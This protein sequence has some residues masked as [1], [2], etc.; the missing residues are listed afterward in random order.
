MKKIL[1]RFLCSLV[2]LVVSSVLE[3]RLLHGQVN[4]NATISS[5]VF[6]QP[7][8]ISTKTE[9][10]GAV[11][12]LLWNGKQFVDIGPQQ[13]DRGREFQ[14]AASF[15]KKYECYNPT[16][17]GANFDSGPTSS[18]QLLWLNASGNTLESQTLMAFFRAEEGAEA[19]CGDRT[20]WEPAPPHNYQPSNYQ[21]HKKITIGYAG[22]QNVIEWI[23]DLW[24]PEHITS[25]QVETMVAIMPYEF[26]PLWSYDLVSKTFRNV[27]STGGED[28]SVKVRMADNNHALAYYSPERLQPY[29]GSNFRW[30]H[31]AD[32]GGFATMGGLH[33]F[34]SFNG[35]GYLGYR[36]YLVI[37]NKDQVKAGLDSLHQQFRNLDPDVFNWRQYLAMY[38]DVAAS[39]PDQTGAEGHWLTYG[40]NEGRIGSRTFS[41][42]SY[43]QLNPDVANAFG[44]TNYSGAIYHYMT[45]GRDEGRGTVPKPAC[46]A[47]HSLGYTNRKVK[48]SGS[49]GNGQ[50]GNGT[51]TSSSSPILI[52][53]LENL[54]TEVASREY[55]SLAVKTDGTL[56]M[57]GSNQNGALGNG[58]VGGNFANAV[59]VVIPTVPGNPPTRVATPLRGGKHGIATGSGACA[60][61]DRDGQVWTWGLNYNGCLG[62]GTTTPHYIPARVKKNFTEYLTGI[63]SISVD[64]SRMAAVDADAHVWTW[65]SG[66][67]GALGN[68]STLDSSY[69]VQVK[70]CTNDVTNPCVQEPLPGVT[71]TACGYGFCI[72][73]T[74]SGYVYGWGNNNYAQLGLTGGGYQTLATRVPISSGGAVKMIAAGG[75]HGLAVSEDG[76]V[77]GWGFNGTGALGNGS[78][79]TAQAP[80]V[81]MS[82]GPQ[83]MNNI[84]DVVAGPFCSLMIRNSD[85]AVFG[86][87][88]NFAGQLGIPGGMSTEYTPKLSSF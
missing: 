48:A 83:N 66:A 30:S 46:G 24:I 70:H 60:A 78:S 65:G 79:N 33:R 86:T 10:A 63:L 41:P 73:L 31:G 44:A 68:G 67:Y 77:R 85:R 40:I 3:P 36:S 19:N 53:N 71:Q 20:Q 1:Q 84:D 62:D 35:P 76:N 37:G 59:E 39:F 34:P 7:L 55:T 88:Q 54:P 13:N 49:N 9:F 23:S 16:E 47:S 4:G 32:S 50:F 56:W 58:T 26:A 22:I 12:S 15:F 74:R 82:A 5:T 11:T 27:S 52:P 2:F 8:S 38:P 17:A 72:A 42:S 6:G 29:D 21:V 18:S 87:G 45:W 43:L 14:T 81:T 61:I 80:P 25:G 75:Y 64:G 28:D 51:F 69:P 57:W